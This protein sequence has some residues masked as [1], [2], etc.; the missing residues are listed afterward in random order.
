M[1]HVT[2]T[3]APSQR[4]FRE[5]VVQEVDDGLRL[6]G[7]RC[8]A[9]EALAFPARVVCARCHGDELE[10]ALLGP[11][12]RLYTFA[13]VRQAP[14]PFE[15]PY[16]IGYVDLDQGVRVFTQFEAD[17]LEALEIGERVELCIGRIYATSDDVV[18]QAYKF[19]PVAPASAGEGAG[20]TH[21]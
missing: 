8:T 18:V 7:S 15:T 5:G 19:R 4:L 16:A 12:G 20:G 10:Q 6:I 1:P 3:D 11:E 17:D 2:S 21:A 13:I 14:A 9:C